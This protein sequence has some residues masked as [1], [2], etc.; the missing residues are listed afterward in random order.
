VAISG[1]IGLL[2][3]GGIEFRSCTDPTLTNVTIWGNFC[4]GPGGGIASINGD[5]TL[6]NTIIW[7]ND[8]TEVSNFGS[9]PAISHSLIEGCEGSGAGWDPSF[10]TDDG[11]NIDED[12]QFKVAYSSAPP[13]SLWSS[14]PAINTGDN[15]AIPAG[16]TTDIAGDP[17]I[18][19][20][21]VDMG[22]YEHQGFKTDADDIPQVPDAFALY[23]NAPNPFNPTTTIRFDLPHAGHV[24][25][26]VYNIKG[27]LVATLADGHM[28]EGQKEVIWTAKDDRGRSVTSGVYFYRIAAGDYIETRKMVLLR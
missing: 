26:T 28:A 17:R 18:Y 16:I 23:Q 14:S 6:K 13:L 22:A 1:N 5:L 27:E 15:T 8:S 11:G 21:I 20:G 7:G 9:T 25:L 3:G 24:R 4:G 2:S 10:G 19:D 12:P